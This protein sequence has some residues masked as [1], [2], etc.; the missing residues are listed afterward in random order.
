MEGKRKDEDEGAAAAL[1]V[2]GLQQFA[3]Y[4]ACASSLRS[5]RSISSESSGLRETKP[6]KTKPVSYL[7]PLARM[8]E[9]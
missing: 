2:E 1:S 5:S 7:T 4:R 8:Q 3:E 6:L 9:R